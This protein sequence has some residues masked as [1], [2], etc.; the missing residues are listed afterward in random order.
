MATPRHV[1][2]LKVFDP[3][4]IP[5]R[6]TDE[7]RHFIKGELWAGSS[8]ELIRFDEFF[9]YYLS[10]IQVIAW[11]NPLYNRVFAAPTYGD[12]KQVITCLRDNF[13]KPKRDA[14]SDL[15]T[16]LPGRN[17]EQYS[18][19]LEF[20]ARIWTTLAIRINSQEIS[21]LPND[22]EWA[23]DTSL[24][25]LALLKFP[26]YHPPPGTSQSLESIILDRHLTASRLR[27]ICRIDVQWTHN[28]ADHLAYDVAND[29]VYIYPHKACLVGHLENIE[30]SHDAQFTIDAD[31]RE[32]IRTLDLL[33]PW[34][35]ATNQFL[36]DQGLSYSQFHYGNSK[37]WSE[38]VDLSEF[39][40]WRY[41]LTQLQTIFNRPP[42]TLQAMWFDRRRPLQWMAF[43]MAGIV[44]I[45]TVLFGLISSYAALKQVDLAQ[46]AY[47][48]D[49]A[50]AC[51]PST[52]SQKFCTY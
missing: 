35:P 18:R 16:K 27:Q 12:L 41:R 19:L 8:T 32:T 22:F 24:R 15:A 48:L 46:K 31:L 47:D 5:G 51:S 2:Y 29:R 21:S 30:T 14:A 10:T 23:D 40:Y 20:A 25:S 45:L 37:Y 11:T 42:M 3:R 38:A 52:L 26:K 36:K 7:V 13:S 1:E 4:A 50:Q 17:S 9:K 34:T 49:L 28:L 6:L 39:R 43:W 44:L 33:L